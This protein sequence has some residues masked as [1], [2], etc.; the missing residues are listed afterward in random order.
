MNGSADGTFS[1]RMR[2]RGTCRFP[3]MWYGTLLL[4]FRFLR[5]MVS[6]K[7]QSLTCADHS[8]QFT[9]EYCDKS[10]CQQDFGQCRISQ[11]P[12]CNNDSP[13]A[14]RRTVGYWRSWNTEQL[15]DTVTPKQIDTSGLTHLYYAFVAVSNAKVFILIV[16]TET[17]FD[18]HSFAIQ[19]VDP[20]SYHQFTARKSSSLQT[21]VVIGGSDFNETFWSKMTLNADSRSSF[22]NSLHA[23]T[24][25]YG[26]E[27][28]NLGNE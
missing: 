11:A 25:K 26:F 23:F 8:S 2:Q 20:D 10:N 5:C 18:E 14:D 19:D 27:G 12:S 24:K 6:P 21:W 28:V 17:Q 16:L 4:N 7:D 15:C 9:K 3:E 22:I 13:S 1:G